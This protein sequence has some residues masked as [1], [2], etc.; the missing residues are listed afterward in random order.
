MTHG[1]VWALLQLK[2]ILSRD[3]WS[4]Q[5]VLKFKPREFA[6]LY[7]SQLIVIVGAVCNA[8]RL[9]FSAGCAPAGDLINSGSLSSRPCWTPAGS[10]AP[11]A[12]VQARVLPP[13]PRRLHP[14]RP[15][16]LFWG[17][18]DTPGRGEGKCLE[19][20]DPYPACFKSLPWLANLSPSYHL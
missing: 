18:R 5:R 8:V 16:H 4:L 14:L 20:L 3:E 11:R 10:W 19:P 13:G 7:Y 15:G 2:L 6:Y 1:D 12:C 9:S 17:G